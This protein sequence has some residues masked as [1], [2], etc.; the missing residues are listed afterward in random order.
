M[1]AYVSS[2]VFGPQ[3]LACFILF[4]PCCYFY[5]L[6]NGNFYC[7]DLCMIQP[8]QMQAKPI[9]SKLSQ[10]N[11]IQANPM[12]SNPSQPIQS[13]PSQSNPIP[14]NPIK[15]KPIQYKPSQAKPVQSNPIPANTTECFKQSLKQSFYFQ[16]V[17]SC[18]GSSCNGVIDMTNILRKC[19][20]YCVLQN[21]MRVGLVA[22]MSLLCRTCATTGLEIQRVGA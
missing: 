1:I 7:F 4:R 17:L 14:A 19:I 22:M 16:P 6:W 5:E 13:Q 9:Q 20:S 11:P 2:L 18:L 3:A 10:A 15:S 8:D 21:K 12:Q